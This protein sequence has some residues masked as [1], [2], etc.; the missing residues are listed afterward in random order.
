MDERRG[1]ARHRMLKAGSIL[2]SGGGTIDCTLRNLS[3]QGA[4]LAVVNPATI[5][6]SFE[7]LVHASHERHLC[8]VAWRKQDRIGVRFV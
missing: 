1:A 7:L 5:P 8:K 2:L 3:A 6:A 4:T